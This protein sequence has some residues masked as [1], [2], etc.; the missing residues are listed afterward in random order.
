VVLGSVVTVLGSVVMAVQ[1]RE[2]GVSKGAAVDEMERRRG[3]FGSKLFRIQA[4]DV[5]T[6]GVGRS[7]VTTDA[8]QKAFFSKKTRQTRPLN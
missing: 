4:T 3:E 5:M 1:A 2:E 8:P 6:V 7:T